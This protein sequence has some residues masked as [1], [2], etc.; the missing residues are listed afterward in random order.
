MSINKV[1]WWIATLYYAEGFPY[2]LIRLLSTPFFKEHKASLEAI[3]LTSLFGIP[4]VLKF[5]WAPVVDIFSSKKRWIVSIEIILILGFIAIGVA[6]LSNRPIFWASILFFLLA[7]IAATHDISI[8]GYYLEKLT[9]QEQAK[10]VGIQSASYRIAL[11]V[12]SGA[13]LAACDHLGWLT[14]YSIAAAILLIL[15]LLHAVFLPQSKVQKNAK[16]L[17]TIILPS[18]LFS[19]LLLSYLLTEYKDTLLVQALFIF[20]D[21]VKWTRVIVTSL[22]I[23]VFGLTISLPFIKNR[24]YTSKSL[25]ARAFVSYL[26]REKI[27]LVLI[28]VTTYRLG[29]ALLQNMAYPFLRDIGITPTQYGIAHNTFGIIAS[30][31]GAIVGGNLIAKYGLSKTIW[32]FVLA[33]NSLNVLYMIMALKYSYILEN[34]YAGKANFPLVTALI[35]VDAFGSGL[36]SAAFTVFLFR[37]TMKEFKASHFAIGTGIM[38]VGSTL[39]GVISGFIASRIGFANYFGLTFLITIPN[40][41]MIPFLPFIKDRG[42]NER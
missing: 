12:S 14:G 42:D 18:L 17:I 11:I 16:K 13:I 29:E 38:N 32:P 9:R 15:L 23:F 34:P 7:F 21:E 26:D 3:G 5:I 4:W 39:A 22:F 1:K 36:G 19:L 8:D 31:L 35:V 20:V 30:L 33:Q 10:F 2:G 6:S 37:T 25:Y 41:I 27:W 28:F 40:M 24:L